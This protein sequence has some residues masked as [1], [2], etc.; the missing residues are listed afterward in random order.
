LDVL[1]TI[2]KVKRIRKAMKKVTIMDGDTVVD[3]VD[4][5]EEVNGLRREQ[6]FFRNQNQHLKYNPER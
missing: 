3:M 6:L 4:A 2:K 1:K 5:I